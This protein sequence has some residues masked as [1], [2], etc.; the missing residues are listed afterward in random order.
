[1][2]TSIMTDLLLLC[3]NEK[4]FNITSN[5]EGFKS[6]CRILYFLNRAI[7]KSDLTDLEIVQL[8]EFYKD[9]CFTLWVDANYIPT[10]KKIADN[11]FEFFI[12]FPSMKI[13]L[14]ILSASPMSPDLSIR[15]ITDEQEIV[16]TWIPIMLK[17]YN[18]NMS[19]PSFDSYYSEWKKFFAY[20]KSSTIYPY[21]HFYLGYVNNTPAATGLFIIKNENVF[22]HWIGTLPEFR[23][24]GLG[25]VITQLPLLEYKQQGISSAYLFASVMGKPIYEK[26]GFKTIASYNVYK[27]PNQEK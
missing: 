1:M 25:T 10:N 3:L 24:K 7:A 8:K 14:A 20:L 21:M 13:D 12:N 4:I 16:S 22:I 9:L 5:I 11:N 17:S 2:L 15:K 27:S 23:G 19:T 6:D 26:L 18:P